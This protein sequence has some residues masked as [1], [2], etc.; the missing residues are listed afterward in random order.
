MDGETRHLLRVV[1]TDKLAQDWKI[2]TI[3]WVNDVGEILKMHEGFLDRVTVRTTEQTAT[4]PND[5]GKLDL[6]LDVG[7]PLK[8]SFAEP[9]QSTHAVY[10]VTFDG[11]NPKDVF[12]TSLSQQ[13]Q[14][15][16]GP[17]AGSA[18]VTVDRVT[19]ESPPT[20]AMEVRPPT[21]ADIAANRL[22]QSDDR[23]VIA[24]AEAVAG[25]VEDPWEAAVALEQ[26]LY[27]GISKTDFSQVFSSAAE[28]AKQRTGDCSEH[29]VLLAATC[30]A[31]G[32]PARVAVGLLYSPIDRRFLYHMWN[33]VWINDRWIPLDATLGNGGVGAAHL[34]F[35]D[36]SLATESAYSMISPVI[37]LIGKLQIELVD[38]QPAQT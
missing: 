31:R 4:R 34:K 29:A 38:V 33:E 19:P 28:V 16:D 17:T 32:I 13:V 11:L 18:L 3:Y 22:I 5:L 9:H 20:V 7:V 14:A 1:S 6:G 15:H 2:P 37:F 12:A 27:L 25:S 21:P 24:I 26:Y 23:R 30:R 10:R 8:Q 35:R 36:S